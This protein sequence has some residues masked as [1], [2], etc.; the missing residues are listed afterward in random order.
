MRKKQ[1]NNDFSFII[2]GEG[3]YAEQ[4]LVY[5]NEIPVFF[6]CCNENETRRYLALCTNIENEDFIVVQ[7]ASDIIIDMLRKRITMRDVFY[8]QQYCWQIYTADDVHNDIVLRKNP[9]ELPSDILPV[10]GAFFELSCP[11]HKEYLLSL[12][13]EVYDFSE[14]YTLN[15]YKVVINHSMSTNLKDIGSN[16]SSGFQ[17]R[18]ISEQQYVSGKYNIAMKVGSAS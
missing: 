10:E 16:I 7:V 4:E 1:M 17:V 13:K 11:E 15:E 8:G 6:V 12:E 2:D 5:D 9:H 3:L 14:E 18:K